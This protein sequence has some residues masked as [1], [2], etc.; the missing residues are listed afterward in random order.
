MVNRNHVVRFD[1]CLNCQVYTFQDDRYRSTLVDRRATGEKRI[2]G[3]AP[4]SRGRKIRKSDPM[5]HSHLTPVEG[6]FVHGPQNQLSRGQH[7]KHV[8]RI[9]DYYLPNQY[10]IGDDQRF[11]CDHQRLRQRV[12]IKNPN[13]VALLK[14]STAPNGSPEHC[15]STACEIRLQHSEPKNERPVETAIY[16]YPDIDLAQNEQLKTYYYR[17]SMQRSPTSFPWHNT[18]GAVGAVALT[19]PPTMLE[20]STTFGERNIHTL[21]KSALTRLETFSLHRRPEC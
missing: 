18:W 8:L 19:Q 7:R 2:H 17:C 6:S 13:D 21:G 4:R 9:C 3:P 16:V 1:D 10:K 14:A 11:F 5:A 20:G 15:L 12:A